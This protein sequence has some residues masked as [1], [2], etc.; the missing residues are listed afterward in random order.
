V[1][2]PPQFE[3]SLPDK[4]GL[5]KW[6]RVAIRARRRWRQSLS[7]TDR[8]ESRFAIR[9]RRAVSFPQFSFEAASADEAQFANQ[10]PFNLPL[11][12]LPLLKLALVVDRC[13]D[14]YAD[15]NRGVRKRPL[16]L[17]GRSPNI[18]WIKGARPNWLSRRRDASV[19][20]N[21]IMERRGREVT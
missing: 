6:S 10:V 15:D 3:W 5:S 16:V 12:K 19:S 1:T 21:A 14:V 20:V 17:A 13:L 4:R 9:I 11:L 18:P 8:P 2:K 7:D